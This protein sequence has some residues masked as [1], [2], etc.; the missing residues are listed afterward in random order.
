MAR[1][2]K[3]L[4]TKVCLGDIDVVS[5]LFFH[6]TKTGDKEPQILQH[7]HLR[8]EQLSVPYGRPHT[9][10]RQKFQVSLCLLMNDRA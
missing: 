4:C 2:V 8:T 7:C 10:A 3:L 5:F 9:G 1:K 6:L